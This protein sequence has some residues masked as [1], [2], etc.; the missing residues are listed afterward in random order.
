MSFLQSKRLERGAEKETR[1]L[2]AALILALVFIALDQITKAA[3]RANL[4]V[5][6]SVPV[7]GAFFQLTHIENSGAAQPS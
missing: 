3:V 7:I 2:I 6:E 4:L 1:T 5:G